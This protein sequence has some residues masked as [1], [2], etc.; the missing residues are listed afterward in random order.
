MTDPT[1][2]ATPRNR[3]S[4]RAIVIVIAALGVA[5]GLAIAFNVSGIRDYLLHGSRAARVTALAVLPFENLSRD[6]KHDY[7]ASGIT[8]ELSYDL[9]LI[10]TIRVIAGNSARKYKQGAKTLAEA[11]R[12]LKVGAVVQ[13]RVRAVGDRV[14]LAVALTRVPEN[15][16][17]WEHEYER[18]LGETPV[19]LAEISRRVA[20]E[21]GAAVPAD[22]DGRFRTARPINPLALDAYLKAS[23]ADPAAGY[24]DTLQDAIRLDPSFAMP[25][26][27]LAGDYYWSNFVPTFPPG[28]T[29]GKVKE[30]AQKALSLDPSNAPAHF[31]LALVNLDYDWNFAEAEKEFRRNLALRRNC[32]A[33]HHLYAHFL[34][35]MGRTE[36]AK[37]ETERA[38]EIDPVDAG[39][40][41]CT[42][43]HDVSLKRYDDAE[44]HIAQATSIGGRGA[45]ASLWLGWAH[46][47]R[48]R[49]DDA[50][51]QFQ[52]AVVSSEGGVLF[53][54]ALAHAYAAAGRQAE[55]REVL[56]RLI[57]RAKTEYV[58]P[59]EIAT[60]HAG[61]GERDR[62]FEWL[63]KAYE[64]REP[65]LTRFR[66]DPRVWSLRADPRF[67]QLLRRMNFPTG[68]A[69]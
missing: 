34:L 61:L 26:A 53:T 32:A 9:S 30:T 56:D 49:Y 15:T 3:H 54:A 40:I 33:T 63:E 66:M 62:A 22:Q 47:Q 50:I 11:A 43:W 35:S 68:A 8:E 27:A 41:A 46:E 28:E 18:P 10:G 60:V 45:M 29:Y 16:R 55:A 44:K 64:R 17:L 1:N 38:L 52:Q 57:A 25:V 6:A 2:A 59:Y 37:A 51:A 21:I 48:Q 4:A 13:G 31:Y 23:Y 14:Q 12:D 36:E 5:I 24:K 58:S 42:A 7:L 20:A 65:F 67:E 19:L 39:L 69:D